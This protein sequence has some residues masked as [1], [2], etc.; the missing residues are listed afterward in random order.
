MTADTIW[1]LLLTLVFPFTVSFCVGR[2][3]YRR[4]EKDLSTFYKALT[5]KYPRSYVK[6]DKVLKTVRKW[7]KMDTEVRIHWIIY[8]AHYLQIFSMFSPV[9][10]PIAC[11]FAP[12]KVVIFFFWVFG[13]G[14]PF[15]LS[16]MLETFW[17]FLQFFRCLKIK[18]DPRYSKTD[19]WHR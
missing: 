17:Y 1:M 4:N 15:A 6:Q 19:F 5:E 3:G 10:I 9:L 8:L 14:C 13:F 16:V 7:F 18:K 2:N 11:F 12:I